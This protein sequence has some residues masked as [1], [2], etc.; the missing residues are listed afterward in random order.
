MLEA[1]RNQF[2]TQDGSTTKNIFHSV[3]EGKNE[4]C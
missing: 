1:E 2:T 3:N 4:R